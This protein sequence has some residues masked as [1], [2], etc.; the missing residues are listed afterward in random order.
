MGRTPAL[1]RARGAQG[2]AAM[3]PAPALATRRRCAHADPGPGSS[4]GRTPGRD[5]ALITIFKKH[6][7]KGMNSFRLPTLSLRVRRGRVTGNHG[8]WEELLTEPEALTIPRYLLLVLGPG[9]GSPG[10]GLTLRRRSCFLEGSR[11][12]DR[13][14]GRAL[15]IAGCTRPAG[16]PQAMT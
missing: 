2:A 1:P 8:G 4:L 7:F 6:V 14:P 13:L 3:Q 12:P 15:D 5:F 9:R 16:P 11:T 10:K